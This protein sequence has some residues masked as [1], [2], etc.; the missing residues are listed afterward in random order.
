MQ[1]VVRVGEGDTESHCTWTPGWTVG[2]RKAVS[3]VTTHQGHVGGPL[4]RP[5]G[6]QT[7]QGSGAERSEPDPDR[8][9]GD[10]I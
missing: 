6:G 8:S 7:S 2:P 5:R 10:S 3:R 9:K 4:P 1:P